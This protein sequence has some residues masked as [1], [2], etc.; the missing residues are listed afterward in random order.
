[1]EEAIQYV[2]EEVSRLKFKRELENFD[3]LKEHYR[4]L[5]VLLLHQSFPDLFFAFVALAVNYKPIVFATCIN[6][7]NYDVEPLSVKFVDPLTFQPVRFT[8]MAT[9]FPRKIEGSSQ[10]QFLLQAE[11]D[12][13]PFL[14]I[15]G[16][17]EYHD[18]IYHNGDLWF[19]YR[20]NGGEGSLC[21]LLDNLQLYGTSHI[22]TYNFQI[23][24][25]LGTDPNRLPL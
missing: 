23:T 7:T 18:H 5:G 8:Q 13:E 6:F 9:R 14:C 19:L 10:P 2:D 20:K 17:R 4:Q 11:R 25:S 16:V 3:R 1:M 12:E 24:M 15:P 22:V 21:F